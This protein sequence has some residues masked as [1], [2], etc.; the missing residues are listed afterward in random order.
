M[1]MLQ[2]PAFSTVFLPFESPPIMIALQLG[3]VGVGPA[4]KLCLSLAAMTVVLLFPLD[5]LWF[6]I[7]GYLP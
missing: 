2:V 4:T 5:F 3:G 7:L 6:R 1:L